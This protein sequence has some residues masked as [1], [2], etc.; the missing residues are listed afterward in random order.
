[1]TILETGVL[2]DHLVDR[3]T[4]KAEQYESKQRHSYHDYGGLEQPANDK[5]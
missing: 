2:P 4:D 3:V 1:M 5:G